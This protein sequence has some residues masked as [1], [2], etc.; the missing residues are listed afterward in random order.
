MRIKRLNVEG[1]KRI[2]EIILD[3]QGPWGVLDWV[4]L[5]REDD[6][7]QYLILLK[8]AFQALKT[9]HLHVALQ[10]GEELIELAPGESKIRE[11]MYRRYI[12]IGEPT[13]AGAVLQSGFTPVVAQHGD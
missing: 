9:K 1:A 3:L 2:I 4:R 8:C 7:T 10:I 13:K 11:W 6:K 12:R 5:R